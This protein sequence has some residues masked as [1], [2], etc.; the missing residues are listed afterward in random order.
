[1]IKRFDSDIT[2]TKKNENE[3]DMSELSGSI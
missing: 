2:E 1:V 3:Q